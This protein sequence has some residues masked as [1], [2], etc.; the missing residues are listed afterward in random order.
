MPVPAV[1]VSKLALEPHVSVEPV[2]L[3]LTSWFDD[4]TA[5][6]SVSILASSSTT[7]LPA[8]DVLAMRLLTVRVVWVKLTLVPALVVTDI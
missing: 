3:Q 8:V 4:A 6:V 5:V 7:P 2:M 1:E